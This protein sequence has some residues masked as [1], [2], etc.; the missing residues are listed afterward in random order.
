[1]TS[2]AYAYSLGEGNTR[3]WAW[4]RKSNRFRSSGPSRYITQ[5]R[6]HGK[7]GEYASR[8]WVAVRYLSNRPRLSNSARWASP[9][10][11]RPLQ[12]AYACAQLQADTERPAS[13][14][15]HRRIVVSDLTVFLTTHVMVPMESDWH[16]L[17]NDALSAKGADTSAPLMRRRQGHARHLLCFT[18]ERNSNPPSPAA[19]MLHVHNT[20]NQHC[21]VM[22]STK[23]AWQHP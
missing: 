21:R 4:P 23:T 2:S 1:M 10:D 7:F 17:M 14:E 6:G 12:A 18:Q 19:I 5:R 9:E 22:Q 11:P 3:L 20:E 13:A 16:F 15:A 8:C